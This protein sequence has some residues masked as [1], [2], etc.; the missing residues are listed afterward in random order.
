MSKEKISSQEIIDVLAAQLNI[1][2]NATDDFLK[3]LF[4]T[5]EEGL[6]SDNSVKIKG[7]GTFKLQWNEPR[8]SVNV[9]TGEEIILSGYNKVTFTPEA[10]L[11][12]SVNEPFAHLEA[13]ILDGDLKSTPA[14]PEEDLPDPL[15]VLNEQASEIKNILSEIQMLSKNEKTKPVED[16]PVVE[17]PEIEEPEKIIIPDYEFVIEEPEFVLVENTAEEVAEEIISEPEITTRVS[18][19]EL[20]KQPEIQA[21]ESTPQEEI[22]EEKETGE[23]P[24]LVDEIVNQKIVKRKKKKS[25]VG[26]FIFLFILL[27][28]I[29][30]ASYMYFYPPAFCWCKY[31]VFTEQNIEKVKETGQHIKEWAISTREKYFGKSTEKETVTVKAD[32]DKMQDAFS[33]PDSV[34]VSQP[35]DSLALLFNQR[36]T[37]TEFIGK[38]R[39]RQGSRLTV[40]SKRYYGNKDFW[41]YIY[42]ANKDKITDPDN[43]KMGTLIKIPKVDKRLIDEKNPR[44]IEFARELHDLYVQKKEE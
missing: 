9:Q 40:M 25:K 10:A 3:A 42:E 8:K 11:K 31:R 1:S 5:I 35:I 23:T 19:K 14:T 33:E 17:E 27:A 36:R 41:V 32:V 7:F 43:I 39:I 2:K 29:G 38:E 26:L 22:S 30:T 24:V 21:Q 44:C 15:R 4:A 18:E 12:D 37:Y 20:E 34:Y 6:A 16:K 13:V 28:A